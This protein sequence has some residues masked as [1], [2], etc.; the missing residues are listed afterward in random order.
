MTLSPLEC[1]LPWVIE[2]GMSGLQPR[3]VIFDLLSTASFKRLQYLLF[4]KESRE[5]CLPATS[6]ANM[7]GDLKNEPFHS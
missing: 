4:V 1:V 3:F 5:A 6:L 7:F 2:V